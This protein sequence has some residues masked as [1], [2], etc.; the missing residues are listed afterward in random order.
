MTKVRK[1]LDTEGGQ[2]RRVDG[3]GEHFGK[4]GTLYPDFISS[5]S[6]TALPFINHSWQ[7]PQDPQGTERSNNDYM[8]DRTPSD[9][10]RIVSPRGVSHTALTDKATNQT[11]ALPCC[12]RGSAT[13]WSHMTDPLSVR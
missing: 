10:S 1:G 13:R 7:S 4:A 6:A 3:I 8:S 2:R 11:T 5:D 9:L 12:M